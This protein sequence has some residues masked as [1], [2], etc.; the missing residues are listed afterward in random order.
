MQSNFSIKLI[1]SLCLTAFFALPLWSQSEDILEE[2][3]II[4]DP[5]TRKASDVAPFDLPFK[6]SLE[7]TEEFKEAF[8]S[9][10][11]TEVRLCKDPGS[12]TLIRRELK[13]N[14]ITFS[15]SQYHF[16][17][18]ENDKNYL[19]IYMPPLPPNKDYD[20]ALI[21]NYN[22]VQLTALLDLFYARS[23]GLVKG[24]DYLNKEK[25][26]YNAINK[27]IGAE[28]FCTKRESYLP[29][30]NSVDAFLTDPGL[31]ATLT[32]LWDVSGGYPQEILA[33]PVSYQQLLTFTNCEDQCLCSVTK[34]NINDK[35]V[36]ALGNL[37]LL[38]NASIYPDSVKNNAPVI[39]QDIERNI[40]LL[41]GV[42]HGLL[43]LDYQNG[44][45]PLHV[46]KID[47]RLANLDSTITLLQS[48]RAYTLCLMLSDTE[49]YSRFEQTLKSIDLLIIETQKNQKKLSGHYS[50]FKQFVWSDNNFCV[51]SWISIGTGLS[52]I[53]KSVGKIIIPDIGIAYIRTKL[54]SDGDALNMIRPY[55]GFNISLGPIHKD[56]RPF[57]TVGK[58][59]PRHAFYFT[60]GLTAI[61]LTEGETEGVQDLFRN[62][63]LLLGGGIR[64]HRGIRLSSG[65]VLHKRE[66]PNPI[67]SKSKIA[68][69]PFIGLSFDMDI[70]EAF[71]LFKKKI[72]E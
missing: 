33:L 72:N 17:D 62:A 10:F 24:D 48:I 64:L 58:W 41:N 39:Y 19:V 40:N 46:T 50:K 42:I 36:A 49:L 61:S 11:F 51:Y 53:K 56:Q 2:D 37:K 71:E 9:S 69:S 54:N 22:K 68:A 29:D 57:R 67:I 23:I 66:D 5:N 18:K 20:I 70:I 7:V 12:K 25:A 47:K 45:S 63:N 15:K 32:G 4:I 14:L 60:I 26:L 34:Y 28:L 1:L 65:V 16:F 13:G 21:S 27:P 3:V 44:A 59:S 52:T 8:E 43:P 35:V 31:N 30:S 38:Y 55:Y 6:V